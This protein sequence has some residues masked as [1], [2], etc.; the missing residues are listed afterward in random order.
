MRPRRIGH[1]IG[2]KTPEEGPGRHEIDRHDV[3]KY[4]YRTWITTWKRIE[5]QKAA[6]KNR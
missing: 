3:E 4:G 6:E 2:S 5:W 1:V